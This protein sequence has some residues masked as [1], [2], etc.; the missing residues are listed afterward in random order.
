MVFHGSRG[1][2]G[3]PLAAVWL[4]FWSPWGDTDRTFALKS[5]R[6]KMVVRMVVQFSSF[7]APFGRQSLEGEGKKEPKSDFD[8]PYIVSTWFFMVPGGPLGAL[9]GQFW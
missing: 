6:S 1:C 2:P 4:A 3:Q 7:F 8:D 5:P 9:W